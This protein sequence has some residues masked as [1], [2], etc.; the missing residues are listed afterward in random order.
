MASSNQIRAR[1]IQIE[2]QN[3]DIAREISRTKNREE[4]VE[5]T[6]S[7]VSTA[8]DS[9]DASQAQRKRRLEQVDTSAGLSKAV[10]TYASSMRE[11]LDGNQYCNTKSHF[12]QVRAAIT[13]QL[14]DLDAELDRLTAQQRQNN[15]T[16]VSLRSQLS[17]ALAEEAVAAAASSQG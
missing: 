4:E 7:R 2:N 8:E 5:A 3:A 16:L 9:F 15:S 17:M 1:I 6:R 10:Q 12:Q 13:K 11:M 14:Q